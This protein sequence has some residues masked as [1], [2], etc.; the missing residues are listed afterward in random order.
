M[1]LFN[2]AF[3]EVSCIRDRFSPADYSTDMAIRNFNGLV[4]FYREGILE[5]VKRCEF[6]FHDSI[7][8][9]VSTTGEHS[10]KFKEI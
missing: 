10:S 9:K 6:H 3:E 7:N 4:K 8:R 5:K 1:R 2:S